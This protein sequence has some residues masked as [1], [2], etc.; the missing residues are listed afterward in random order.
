MKEAQENGRVKTTN[1]VDYDK[2]FEERQKKLG[3]EPVDSKVDTKGM[4]KTQISQAM[5]EAQEKRAADQL[6]GNDSDDEKLVQ[7]AVKLNSE[8]D[9]KDFGQSTA[10]ILYQGKTPYRVENF[11]RELCKDLPEHCDAKQIKK[12]AD[13]LQV[14]F[15]QKNIQDKE[16]SKKN[17]KAALKHGGQDDKY[18]RNNNVAMINDVMGA[19]AVADDGYGDYGDY[20]DEGAGFTKEKE[21]EF[22]F[23]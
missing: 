19:T 9:Y 12:I 6:F 17:K 4:S 21:G 7:K 23:M 11:F 2:K 1:K 13:H 14:I 18:E 3:G 10:A 15:N 16:K 8:K 22:D 20:G 5:E